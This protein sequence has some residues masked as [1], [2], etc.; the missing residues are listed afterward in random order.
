MQG[1]IRNDFSEGAIAIGPSEPL[2]RGG[3]DGSRIPAKER[4]RTFWF[5]SISFLISGFMVTLVSDLKGTVKSV[6]SAFSTSPPPPPS[7]VKTHFF[8]LQSSTCASWR[9]TVFPR[10]HSRQQ[11]LASYGRCGPLEHA[12]THTHTHTHTAIIPACGKRERQ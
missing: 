7:T 1:E 10:K 9:Y 12:R 2:L 11:S 5:S 3:G 4:G 6:Q 8:N